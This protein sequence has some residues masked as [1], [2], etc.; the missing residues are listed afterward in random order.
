[1]SRA[2]GPGS[3]ASGHIRVRVERMHQNDAVTEQ[4]VSE[5]PATAPWRTVLARITRLRYVVLSM[6]AL[7]AGIVGGGRGDWN[8]FVDAGRDMLGAG[9]LSV[10]VR[11][12]DVQT[13]P[14]SLLLARVLS[15]T[16]RNGFVAC[17]VLCAV[18]GLVAVRCVELA[19]HPDRDHDPQGSE[20][21]TLIGGIV[22]V[23]WW[24]KLGGYGHLDDALVLA[25]AAGA[26]LSVRRSRTVVGAVLLGLAIATKPWAVILVPLTMGGIG[27]LRQRLR[28]PIIAVCIGALLWLPFLVAEPKTLQSMRPTVNIA[29][30]SVLQLFG[31]T[32]DSI[33]QW[34][35]TAQLLGAL[36]LAT[37]VMWRGRPGGVILVAI[38]C[39]MM[40]DPGTWSYYTAGFML[41]A[42]AWDLYETR[43]LMPRTTLVAAVLL[44]PPWIVHSADV[45]AVMRLTACLGAI[46][47]VTLS[48]PAPVAVAK[49]AE[50]VSVT[51]T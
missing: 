8:V 36:L 45:R 37:L 26:L 21:T 38:A 16:P 39:R 35:R 27:P 14:L 31:V 28:S 17:A 3:F 48:R 10:F 12:P 40:T 6:V 42:L 44:L 29:P 49:P 22:M 50:S 4:A 7:A 13:G 46:A 51:V 15:I 18:L 33:P 19:R 25:A 32:N 47:L 24:A 5:H 34:L 20:L 11:H 1:M 2:F 43:S 9:G 30:D 41:G 23:F